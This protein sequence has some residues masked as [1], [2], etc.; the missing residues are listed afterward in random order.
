M[1]STC[2]DRTMRGCRGEEVRV[3]WTAKR[4]IRE[5]HFGSSLAVVTL[6]VFF[7]CTG[8]MAEHREWFHER[9]DRAD[10]AEPVALGAPCTVEAMVS[11]LGVTHP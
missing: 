5:L 11:W 8:F 2:R 6:L 9:I 4:V 3:G 1:Q 10:L 7:A